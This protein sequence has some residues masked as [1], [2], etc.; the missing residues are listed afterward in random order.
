MII[1][2]IIFFIA[3]L[4]A[5]G[6]LSFRAWQIKTSQVVPVSENSERTMPELSFRQIEKNMLYLTKHI[7]QA[8]VLTVA[9]YWFILVTKTKKWV[10]DK[11]PKVHLFFQKKPV[12][13]GPVKPSFIQRAV[14]E[15]KSKI[16]R[17]KERVKEEHE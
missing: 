16:K 5:F 14:L 3:I 11:W 17:I 6:M 2:I 12:S 1:T 15:S 13:E 7:V 9:K 10:M 8:L 4:V